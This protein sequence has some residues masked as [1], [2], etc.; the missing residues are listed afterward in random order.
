MFVTEPSRSSLLD[1]EVADTAGLTRVAYLF[2]AGA[3]QACVARVRSPHGV[4]MQDLSPALATKLHNLVDEAPFDDPRLKDLVNS[5]IHDDT[6]FEHVIT[7]LDSA[8]SSLHRDFAEKMKQEFQQVLRDRLDLIRSD[9]GTE[10]T[11]LYSVLID[12]H[13]IPGC[14]EHLQALLTTNYDEYLES[15]IESVTKGAP[16]F[17]VMV[18]AASPT[19]NGP[20][21]L[22]LHGSLGW[23]DTWPISTE[24]DVGRTLWIPPG[25]HKAK[26]DY[27]FNVLWGRAAE[28]LNCDVLRIIGC[29]LAPNDWDLIAL[30]FASR[31][32][33]HPTAPEI[34]VI[35]S[36]RHVEDLKKQYPYL[37]I[38][39]ML[40]D[41]P[42]GTRIMA[43]IIGTIT[44][45]YVQ[46]TEQEQLE[47]VERAGWRR[48]WFELWLT[49]KV[50]QLNEDLDTV[51]TTAGVVDEFIGR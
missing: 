29:R 17:G 9:H 16:D 4:L 44:K 19:R 7:F 39:S 41:H 31:H 6:D 18:N 25:I 40:E 49:Q 36:P 24:S 37:E 32:M 11:E 50:E 5:V 3:T 35:D 2:G 14:P 38:S 12:F 46:L 33:N 13:N 8:P 20:Q 51:A 30:L 26:Q 34:Q 10:P 23:R 43:D 15:A 47:I 27:P 45:P 22:K 1:S 42:V 28:T 21:L 48:N